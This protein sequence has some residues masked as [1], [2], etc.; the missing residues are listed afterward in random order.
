M[1]YKT[2]LVQLDPRTRGAAHLGLAFQLAGKFGAHLVGL[3]APGP[4]RIPSYALAEAG[5]AL[6]QL[7]DQH[8]ADAARNAEKQ[9]RDAAAKHGD[10]RAEWRAAEG[11]TGGRAQPQRALRRPGGRRAGRADGRA[12]VAHAARRDRAGGR[13]AGAVRAVCRALCRCRASACWSPGTAGARPR[14]R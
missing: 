4:A 11:D 9:F 5:P 3:Y 2:I 8:R 1:T 13:P 7:V 6:R 12:R 10:A 14:A